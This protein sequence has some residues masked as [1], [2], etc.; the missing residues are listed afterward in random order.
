[1]EAL[2]L[3]PN[4]MFAV[5]HEPFGIRVT[6]YHKSRGIMSIL[7]ALKKDEVDFLKNS[8]FG[9]FISLADKPSFSG[10]FGWVIISW[11]LKVKKKHE[12]WILFAEKPIRFSL[13]EYAIVIGLPCG[14]FPKKS[15]KKLKSNISETP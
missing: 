10:R 15:K 1:M 13:R 5:G 4:R 7:N 6:A 2:P 3:L 11:Q 9:K 12:V 8:A 14:K